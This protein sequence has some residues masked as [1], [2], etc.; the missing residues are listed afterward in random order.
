MQRNTVQNALLS[1]RRVATRGRG[2]ASP[3]PATYEDDDVVTFYVEAE[4]L[5]PGETAVVER[6]GEALSTSRMLDVG[7]G[8]GRTT[9]FFLDRVRSYVA[10]DY[11]ARMVD[12]CRRRFSE[13]TSVDTF[14]EG[15][16]RAMTQ[17]P[18]GAFDLV[19]FSHNGIDSVEPA[20]RHTALRE[21]H[22]VC[23]PGGSLCFSSHNLQ[24]V[25][26]MLRPDW[27][28]TQGAAGKAKLAAQQTAV[29]LINPSPTAL[30]SLDGALIND[31]THQFRL[32]QY[33][34]RPYSQVRELTALGFDDITLFDR[35]GADI[36]APAQRD[37]CTDDWV[38]YLCS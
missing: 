27:R 24:A 6:L 26:R 9:A 14:R 23:A 35:E 32:R 16:V 12:A 7:V 37:R 17:F 8:G 21:L 1:L 11:S 34:V 36:T 29:R 31:G 4:G 10:I 28:S 5:Q 3:N 19:L 25:N 2:E 20:D 38:T 13:Q 22:R 18:D 30:R 15:D 33:Y